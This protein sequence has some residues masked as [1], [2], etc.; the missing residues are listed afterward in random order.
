LNNKLKIGYLC[1]KT[2]SGQLLYGLENLPISKGTTRAIKMT[3]DKL[4]ELGHTLVPFEM[5]H[6]E[7]IEMD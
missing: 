5:T 4:K 1:Y 2:P 6:A 3:I 7:F